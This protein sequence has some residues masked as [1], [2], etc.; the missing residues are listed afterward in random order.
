MLFLTSYVHMVSKKVS[1]SVHIAAVAQQSALFCYNAVV[2]STA[3]TYFWVLWKGEHELSS[4]LAL[5]VHLLRN[6]GCQWVSRSQTS[7]WDPR[8]ESASWFRKE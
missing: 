2:E 3:L 8:E 5:M 7:N 1:I 6:A 4:Q